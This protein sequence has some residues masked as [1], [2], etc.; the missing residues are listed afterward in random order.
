VLEKAGQTMMTTTSP[1][2]TPTQT[3]ILQLIENHS[4]IHLSSAA[5]NVF[6]AWG[7]MVLVS[8]KPQNIP[9]I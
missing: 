8:I 3:L 2:T 1:R 4:I 7:G 5:S 9:E 6:H